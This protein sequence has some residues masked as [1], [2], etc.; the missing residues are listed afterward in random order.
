MHSETFSIPSPASNSNEIHSGKPA[1]P[2][3]DPRV[4]VN[5]RAPSEYGYVFH[6][7]L[8]PSDAPKPSGV[9]G[10]DGVVFPRGEIVPEP[11]IPTLQCA[12]GEFHGFL[13]TQR[14]PRQ[15]NATGT[16]N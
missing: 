13:R 1:A 11:P 9:A 15:P 14:I 7:V 2:P 3:Q 12:S 8:S 16:E 10:I 5:P 6:L 4:A